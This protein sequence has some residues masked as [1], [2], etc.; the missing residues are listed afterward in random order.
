VNPANAA[1][2]RKPLRSAW[3]VLAASIVVSGALIGGTHGY[4][5]KEKRD[6]ADGNRRLQEAR[7]RVENLR[8]ERGNLE[9]SAAIFQA[10]VARGLMQPERRL[11]LVE[12]M[13]G[14][15]M[16]HRILSVD[17]EVA[18][19]RPLALAGGRSFPAVD[20]IASRITVKALALHEGDLLEF[21]QALGSSE[22]GF[23]PI[24]RCHFK[25]L[26]T[27][28]DQHPRVEAGCTLEWI[29]IKEKRI[30]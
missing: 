27:A 28:W 16:Q 29:T 26:D 9:Q 20:V 25:R 2:A 10:L 30:A 14:L 18:P 12:L 19:Q 21:L 11:D 6:A 24:D 8:R 17:Y 15:R 5:E 3:I 7:A 23:H 4:L 1:D 13:N 22:Q